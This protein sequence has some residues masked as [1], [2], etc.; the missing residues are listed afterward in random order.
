MKRSWFTPW[1]ARRPESAEIVC[2]EAV[3]LVTAYLDDALEPAARE[4]LER[5]L[6][7]CAHCDEYFAQIRLV[8][9][10]AAQVEPEDLAPEARADLSA[11]FLSWRNDTE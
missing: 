1:R 3:E 9:R 2:R 10:T 7:G 6:A 5:H 8:Q 11:L 4:A